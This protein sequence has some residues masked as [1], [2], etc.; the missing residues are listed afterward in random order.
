[1]KVGVERTRRKQHQTWLEPGERE[2]QHLENAWLL[3]NP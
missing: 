1:M 3:E 2:N